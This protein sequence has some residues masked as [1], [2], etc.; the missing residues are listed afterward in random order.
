MKSPAFALGAILLLASI[1]RAEPSEADVDG[2][3]AAGV[4]AYQQGDHR[5]ALENF[6]LAYDATKDP[7]LLYAMA[8]SERALGHCERAVPLFERFIRDAANDQQKDAARA[9]IER[10]RTE[11]EVASSAG[12]ETPPTASSTPTEAAPT[13]SAPPNPSSA[14]REAPSSP[15]L[16]PSNTP[17]HAE[18]A[19]P[20]LEERNNQRTDALTGTLLATGVALGAVGTVLWLQAGGEEDAARRLAQNPERGDYQSNIDDF[21]AINQKRAT[22]RVLILGGGLLVGLGVLRYVTTRGDSAN[23][24]I[25]PSGALAEF[26]GSF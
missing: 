11:P 18:V 20:R 6:Q 4:A 5:R 24:V 12:A 7:A 14:A 3:R 25:S 10:C 15:T 13:P 1:G 19:K 9:N 26:S 8:Q 16:A 21:R 17:S 2:W 22:A 23:V